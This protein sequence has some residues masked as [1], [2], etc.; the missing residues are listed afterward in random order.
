M[1]NIKITYKY[2]PTCGTCVSIYEAK[3]VS[4]GGIMLV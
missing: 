3:G 2:V 1:Y 4:N